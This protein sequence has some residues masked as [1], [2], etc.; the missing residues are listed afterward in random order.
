MTE[1]VTA[2]DLPVIGELPADLNGRYLR[3]GPNPFEDVDPAAHHWFLGDGMV[4]GI[5]LREGRAKWY[6]NRYVGG[7]AIRAVRGQPDLFQPRLQRVGPR[8]E[9]QRRWLRRHDV[10]DGRGRRHTGHPHL[11]A[12]VDRS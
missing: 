6:R 4:H 3:N 1:E 2:Y 11:R 12:R 10:G 8:A 9:H 7:T 5:R